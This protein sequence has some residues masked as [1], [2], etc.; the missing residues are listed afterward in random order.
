MSHVRCFTRFFL[1]LTANGNRDDCRWRYAEEGATAFRKTCEREDRCRVSTDARK[2]RH[3]ACRSWTHPRPPHRVWTTQEM[4]LLRLRTR[5][6][7]GG[8][9]ILRG[10]PASSRQRRTSCLDETAISSEVS[11]FAK[12]LKARTYGYSVTGTDRIHHRRDP[13]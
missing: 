1:H 4:A 12:G 8:S 7:V 3:A 11:N 5:R 6:M 10:I 13:Q 9:D 2:E